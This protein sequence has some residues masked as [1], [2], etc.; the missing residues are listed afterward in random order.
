MFRIIF[1][2]CLARIS[3]EHASTFHHHDFNGSYDFYMGDKLAVLVELCLP[4]A[5]L[6]DRFPAGGESTDCEYTHTC[7]I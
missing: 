4:T 2:C 7:D 5:Q 3:L 1:S 6:V